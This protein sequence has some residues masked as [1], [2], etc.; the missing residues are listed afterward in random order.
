MRN[1]R[2]VAGLFAQVPTMLKSH[3]C[4]AEF[5]SGGPGEESASDLIPVV[6]GSQ[7]LVV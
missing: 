6:G 5:A 2:N 1:H 3:V 4:L 7:F